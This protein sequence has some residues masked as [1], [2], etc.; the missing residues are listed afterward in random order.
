VLAS[1][2]LLNGQH[3]YHNRMRWPEGLAVGARWVN[4]MTGWNAIGFFQL[5]HSSQDEWQG[6]RIK[7]YPHLHNSACRGDVQHSLQ[8]DRPKREL[9]PEI[10]AVHLESQLAKLGANWKGRKTRPFGP[11]LPALEKANQCS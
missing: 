11:P 6:A 4:Q 9:L 8:W 3:D 1:G 10:I 7:P 5:W 2:Y